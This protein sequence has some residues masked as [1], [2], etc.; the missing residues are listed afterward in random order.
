MRF[1]QA[2]NKQDRQ[3]LYFVLVEN[4]DFAQVYERWCTEKRNKEKWFQHAI[5]HVSPTVNY[6][7][8]IILPANTVTMGEREALAKGLVKN[9][10]QTCLRSWS[11]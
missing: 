4:Y 6:H 3:R 7:V 11:I 2:L 9:V 8:D 1:A 5:F 10:F